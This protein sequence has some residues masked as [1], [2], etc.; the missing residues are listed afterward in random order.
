VP[1]AFHHPADGSLNGRLPGAGADVV[2]DHV[3]AEAGQDAAAVRHVGAGEEQVG[4]RGGRGSRDS[5][6]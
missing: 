6:L 1:A 3:E 2:P 5:A 4:E